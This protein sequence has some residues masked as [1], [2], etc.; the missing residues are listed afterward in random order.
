[1]G[2]D[3]TAVP[4]KELRIFLRFLYCFFI[5]H[6]YIIPKFLAILNSLNFLDWHSK[7]DDYY[8]IILGMKTNATNANVIRKELTPLMSAIQQEV[9]QNARENYA[10]SEVKA[11]FNNRFNVVFPA[12]KAC[13]DSL[14]LN[15]AKSFTL[16]EYPE[17]HIYITLPKLLSAFVIL[18]YPSWEFSDLLSEAE[19]VKAYKKLKSRDRDALRPFA[20]DKIFLREATEEFVAQT[21]LFNLLDELCL[22]AAKLLKRNKAHDAALMWLELRTML[23]TR[24]ATYRQCLREKVATDFAQKLQSACKRLQLELK[25]IEL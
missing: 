12:I 17:E 23:E 7:N 11:S 1:M 4:R 19:I 2:S 14:K 10:K 8:A 16:P 15:K 5:R 24:T 21:A 13:F 25:Y 22:L 18:M 20:N 3:P 9:A 6:G